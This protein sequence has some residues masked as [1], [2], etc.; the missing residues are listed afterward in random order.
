MPASNNHGEAGTG[1][2]AE[3]WQGYYLNETLGNKKGG[4]CLLFFVL[5]T[6]LAIANVHCYFKAETHFCSC[7][8]C[9]HGVIS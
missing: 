7:W 8:F 3:L 4:N 9:P 2:N 5:L 6:I 1:N